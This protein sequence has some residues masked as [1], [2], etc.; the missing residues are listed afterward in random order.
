VFAKYPGG[1]SVK[2]GTLP[3]IPRPSSRRPLDTARRPRYS[4]GSPRN[5]GPAVGVRG[6]CGF[7][8]SRAM[9]DVVSR[10]KILVAAVVFPAAMSFGGERG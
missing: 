8:D 4:V 1:V 3:L 7:H 6:A 9:E 5:G 10:K 2:L